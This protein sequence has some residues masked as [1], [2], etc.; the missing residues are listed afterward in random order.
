MF[1]EFKES[2]VIFVALKSLNVLSF[3]PWRRYVYQYMYLL[4]C[5]ITFFKICNVICI[6]IYIYKHTVCISICPRVWCQEFASPAWKRHGGGL[7]TAA[8][9]GETFASPTIDAVLAAIVTWY[10]ITRPYTRKKLTC[11]RKWDYLN[12]KYIFQSLIFRGHVGFP[13]STRN[14]GEIHGRVGFIIHYSKKKYPG[15]YA[16]W[17]KPT[18]KKNTH[19][20]GMV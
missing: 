7:L 5:T 13:G 11:P 20:V 18:K 15:S 4:L 16:G 6:F 2:C 17:T 19:T 9:S 8:I 14:H 12:R 3:L 1:R 10:D